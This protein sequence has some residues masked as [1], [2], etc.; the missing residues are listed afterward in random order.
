MEQTL[1]WDC[2]KA[3]TGGCSWSKEFRPVEGWEA[4]ATTKQQFRGEP[5]RSYL[6]TACSEFERDAWN[7]GL[8]RL[9]EKKPVPAEIEGDGRVSWWWVCGECHSRVSRN[10]KKC[11][12]CGRTI[13]WKDKEGREKNG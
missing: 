3:A 4:K 9:E 7:A 11:R 13:I 2:K 6:V 1:C 12:V 8:K 5:M 10:A